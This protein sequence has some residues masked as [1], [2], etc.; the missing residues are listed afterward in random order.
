MKLLLANV[1]SAE[2]QEKDT[3]YMQLLEISLHTKIYQVVPDTCISAHEIQVMSLT[4]LIIYSSIRERQFS[5]KLSESLLMVYVPLFC[6]LVKQSFGLLWV[7][8]TFNVDY[9]QKKM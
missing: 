6:L 8:L 9:T 4:T 2:Q 3:F 5:H 1:L 7:P